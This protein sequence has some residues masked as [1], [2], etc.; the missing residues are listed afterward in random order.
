MLEFMYQKGVLLYA[1]GD[2]TPVFEKMLNIV[3]LKCLI[4]NIF[5]AP[6]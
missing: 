6:R 3:N 5:F 4:H 1:G 2:N